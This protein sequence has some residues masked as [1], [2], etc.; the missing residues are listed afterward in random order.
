MLTVHT[1][2]Q[3]SASASSLAVTGGGGDEEDVPATMK[4]T[5]APSFTVVSAEGGVGLRCGTVT[6]ARPVSYLRCRR[7]SEVAARPTNGVPLEWTSVFS[8]WKNTSPLVFVCF[9]L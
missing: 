7:N 9:C 1:C 5:G 6:F 3:A 2:T 8:V 4:R